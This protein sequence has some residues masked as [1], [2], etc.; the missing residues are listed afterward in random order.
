MFADCT[1]FSIHGDI[2]T[3][4]WQGKSVLNGG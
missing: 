4:T 2:T 3:G 1:K